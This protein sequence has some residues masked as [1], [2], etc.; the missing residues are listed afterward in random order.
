MKMEGETEEM[1]A[2]AQV[3]QQVEE[4]AKAFVAHYYYLFDNSR[5][6]LVSLYNEPNSMLSFEGQ[7][8]Q[9]ANSIVAKLSSLP[10][11]QCKHNISTIDCQQS[12]PAN[13]ILV[14]VSGNLQL[15]GEEHPLRFSQMF[16]L[17]A[18]PEGNFYVQND[19]FRLNYG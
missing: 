9:G 16:H 11:E 1:K 8:F 14:F 13:G 12:G 15:P 2:M 7:K 4:V 19:I 18:T 17:L 6:S 5:A 3:Q 10:F